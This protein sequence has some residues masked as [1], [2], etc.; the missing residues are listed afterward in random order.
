MKIK[1]IVNI[2]FQYSK[3][4][5]THTGENQAIMTTKYLSWHFKVPTLSKKLSLDHHYESVSI[6]ND[7]KDNKDF[8]YLK[9]K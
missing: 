5:H 6:S 3:N 1:Q 9:I 4:T 2:Y 7:N 8:K